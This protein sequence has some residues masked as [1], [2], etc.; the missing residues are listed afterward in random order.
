MKFLLFLAEAA[1]DGSS[2]AV[3]ENAVTL[4]WQALLDM[5]VN[6]AMTTGIKIVIAILILL[7]SFA[8]INRFAKKV[9]K[10]LENKNGEV[11]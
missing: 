7:I 2:D 5:L 11:K 1:A 6:W 9:Y 4:D 10:K 8:I 3:A